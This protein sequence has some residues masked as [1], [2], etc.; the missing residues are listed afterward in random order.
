MQVVMAMRSAAYVD[1]FA[2]PFGV[3]ELLHH[4]VG[5]IFAWDA[6][7]VAWQSFAVDTVAAP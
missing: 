6:A 3:G 5:Y 4:E 2:N 1:A 7:A